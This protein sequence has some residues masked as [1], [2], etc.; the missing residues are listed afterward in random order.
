[1]PCGPLTSSAPDIWIA[2][3]S[4]GLVISRSNLAVVRP[5]LGSGASASTTSCSQR[6][7]TKGD[8]GPLN[9]PSTKRSRRRCRSD[10]DVRRSLDP[11]V[12]HPGIRSGLLRTGRSGYAAIVNGQLLASGSFCFAQSLGPTKDVELASAFAARVDG[13][14]EEVYRRYGA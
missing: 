8:R 10:S 4:A 11:P 12:L 3:F 7:W 13:A 6:S 2:A 9:G 1:M 14:L 5:L